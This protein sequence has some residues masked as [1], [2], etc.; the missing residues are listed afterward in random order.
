VE[1]TA[2]PICGFSFD[3]PIDEAELSGSYWICDCCGCEYGYDDTPEYRQA[4]L[5][6]GAP[7]FAANKPSGWQPDEQLKRAIPDWVNFYAR[8]RANDA[9][10]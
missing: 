10:S 5:S 3:T 2:C 9:A 4:W 6:K 8:G 7:W 1:L